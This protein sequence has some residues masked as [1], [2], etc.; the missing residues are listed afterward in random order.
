[1]N[2]ILLGL[3]SLSLNHVFDNRSR[4]GRRERHYIITAYCA[5]VIRSSNST[6]FFSI[7]NFKI[8]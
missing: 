7:F 8:V 1:M 6:V 2:I 4:T 3:Y 5:K